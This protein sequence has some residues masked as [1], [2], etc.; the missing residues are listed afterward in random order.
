M[1]PDTE[2]LPDLKPFLAIVAEGKTLTE[3]EAEAAFD[4]MM[5]GCAAKPSKKSPARCARCATNP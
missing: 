4:V 3:A 1:A 5:S 2:Q